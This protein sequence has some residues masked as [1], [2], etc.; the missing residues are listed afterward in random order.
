MRLALCASLCLGFL[1]L[2]SG[3]SAEISPAAYH[4]IKKIP[5]GEEGSWD[6][7]TIDADARRLYI[8]R[9]DRVMVMDIDTGQIVGKVA[10]T[11]GVHGV[12]LVPKLNKG[13]SSN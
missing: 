7:L 13:Y 9:F 8:T 11:P 6:Y 2:G 5:V 3:S 12:A 4:V 1:T 10:K